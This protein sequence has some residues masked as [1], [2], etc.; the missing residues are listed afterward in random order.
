MHPLTV[1]AD[2]LELAK[3]AKDNKIIL[4]YVEHGSTNVDS[5]I[6]VTLKKEVAITEFDKRVG[7]GP[8]V[9]EIDD[10]FDDLNEILGDYA[11]TE[12][13]I[14]RKEII[15]HV[16]NNS[17]VDNV[18]DCDMLYE[19]EGVGPIKNFKEVEV[20]ADNETKEESVESDLE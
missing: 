12:K 1:D 19:I 3:Y 2:M 6:F 20:D 16:G 8:I 13:E 15:V 4:V 11:N 7:I 18:V 17:T 10:H 9:V 5:S 14:T